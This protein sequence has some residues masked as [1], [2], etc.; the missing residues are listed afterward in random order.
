MSDIPYSVTGTGA[1]SVSKLRGLNMKSINDHEL[2]K[3]V[4]ATNVGGSLMSVNNIGAIG[5]NGNYGNNGQVMVSNGSGSAVTWADQTDTTY[6]DGTG[7]SINASNEISIG[8]S[9]ATTDPVTFKNLTLSKDYFSFPIDDPAIVYEDVQ[10]GGTLAQIQASGDGLAAGKLRFYT[11]PIGDFLTEQ[12]T[13]KENGNVGI[14][15]TA[16]VHKLEVNGDI[17]AD[18]LFLGEEG[19]TPKIDLFF[20]DG[21]A[22]NDIYKFRIEVG[23]STDFISSPAFPPNDAY[24]MN[25][26]A[27][28]DA[29]F[30]G[31]ESFDAGLNWRPLLRWGDDSTDTPFRIVSHNPSNSFEFGT[32]GNYK[33]SGN[34]FRINDILHVRHSSS[35]YQI[36]P[37]S[38]WSGSFYSRSELTLNEDDAMLRVSYNTGGEITK[39]QLS[40]DGTIYL[41][42]NVTC[43]SNLSAQTFTPT[44][45]VI[46][47]LA[48]KIGQIA[49]AADFPVTLEVNNSIQVRSLTIPYTGVW[50]IS[51]S[52]FLGNAGNLTGSIVYPTSIQ[53]NGSTAQNFYGT[54]ITGV[55]GTISRNLT[56]NDV[57]SFSTYLTGSGS[58]G[59]NAVQ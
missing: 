31:I 59:M 34:E 35:S 48:G 39:L 43:N 17:K 24:G 13:I 27:N 29:L 41:T 14:G 1:S 11:R 3:K 45:S 58:T 49:V 6:S 38:G 7:V 42:G 12:L 19:A 22:S 33:I 47:N 32:D 16:P 5:M 20:K 56:A 46:P 18:N 28:S 8:Q 37:N 40:K 9:V 23:K 36:L 52:L 51:M 25:I 53:I 10:N 54:N 57:V 55:N 30:V 4:D 21:I 44:Y 50:L 15:T 2:L 26:Q